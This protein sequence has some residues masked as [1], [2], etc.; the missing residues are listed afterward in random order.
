MV[1]H[2]TDGKMCK[3]VESAGLIFTGWQIFTKIAPKLPNMTYEYSTEVKLWKSVLKGDTSLLA[4]TRWVHARNNVSWSAPYFETFSAHKEQCFMICVII[5]KSVT[6][7]CHLPKLIW[8][9]TFE[10]YE[11]PPLNSIYPQMPSRQWGG[12]SSGWPRHDRR[13]Y[14]NAV[15]SR[16]TNTCGPYVYYVHN[17]S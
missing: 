13:C 17:R 4:L 10:L 2:R 16:E 11:A 3:G 1:S 14:V 5:W 6:V 8:W 7:C 15:L 12:Y 9:Y